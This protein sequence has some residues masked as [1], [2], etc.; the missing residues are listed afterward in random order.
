MSLLANF[1]EVF[2]LL[3][4]IALWILGGIWIAK[5]TFNLRRNEQVMVGV[6]VGLTLEN[7]LANLIGHFIDVPFA[8]W[9]SAGLVFFTGILFSLSEIKKDKLFFFRIPIYPLQWVLLIL[10]TYSF[11][12]MGRG[13]GLLDDFQNLPIASFIATG[14]IPPHFSLNPSISY[15]YHYAA[16]L[17]AGQLM[18]IGNFFVWTAVDLARALGFSIALILVALWVQRITNSKMAGLLGGL[19]AAFG[20][21]TRW[22][23]LLLPIQITRVLSEH[24]PLLGSGSATAGTFSEAMLSPWAASGM[25]PYEYPFAFMNGFNSP[26]IHSLH[27]G[28]GGVGM[29][30]GIL[31]L[32]THN[33]FR[34][35][36]GWIVMSAIL[37]ASALS[38]EV[39]YL[40]I[41]AG[42]VVIALIYML[43]NKTWRLPES[44]SRWFGLLFISGVFVA[45]QGGVLSGIFMGFVNNLA[46]GLGGETAYHTFNFH[47]YWPP[48]M[49]SSHLGYLSFGNIYQL[50]IALAEIGPILLVLP[51][52]LVW[53][54]KAFRNGRWYE[55]IYA[56]FAILS[57]PLFIVEYSGT[58]GLTALTRVQ[59]SIIA[60]CKVFAVP[61]LWLWVR[62]RSDIWKTAA[63]G[64]FSITMVSGILIFAIQVIAVPQPVYSFYLNSLDAKMA[65]LYWNELD[66][67]AMIFDND[68]YR[69]P[70]IFG[71]ANDS[72]HNA[73]ERTQEWDDLY[74][75]P[76]PVILHK[77][78][79]DYVY[80]DQ[81]YWRELSP[82][83]QNLLMHNDCVKVIE[84]LVLEFPEET[85][86]LL[87]VK[88][89]Q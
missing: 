26:G 82:E 49:L 80:Y 69:S 27:S 76:D 73:F 89:C 57:L 63:A 16:M 2:I 13:L 7:F 10:L 60:L 12:M 25:G 41:W 28:V 51:L 39:L 36:R 88:K 43:M 78:G 46:P 37:A 53:G 61:V 62:H 54:Y 23:L 19:M 86:T 33:R 52:A 48:A 64:L 75:N 30:A 29:I 50:L 40:Q 55:A 84:D 87:D 9:L 31:L 11:F 85:R 58:A 74:E 72:S 42:I 65:D 24:V 32:L 22:L 34:G 17:F 20:G 81:D 71:R 15:G 14:D 1:L 79:Y 45:F 47:L 21:G 8:F 67:D 44:L 18:R 3:V 77:A 66:S 38:D 70:V 5:R 83:E 56:V 35:W 6:A 68:P 4:W 59:N